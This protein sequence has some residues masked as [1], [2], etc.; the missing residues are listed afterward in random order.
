MDNPMKKLWFLILLA[1]V[2]EIKSQNSIGVGTGFDWIEG[3]NTRPA[4]SDKDINLCFSHAKGY[5]I[6]EARQGFR[7]QEGVS[8]MRYST[9]MSLGLTTPR[10]RS[11]VFDTTF[12]LVFSCAG[13]NKTEKYPQYPSQLNPVL[14]MSFNLR[15]SKE[16]RFFIG[17]DWLVSSYKYYQGDRWGEPVS[18][19]GITGSALLSLTYVLLKKGSMQK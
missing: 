16:K 8:A 19:G 12:G 6:I 3:Y 13:R 9:Y 17:M 5:G 15:L 2:F 18:T 4:Y 10:D 7:Y 1:S 14:K 11:F